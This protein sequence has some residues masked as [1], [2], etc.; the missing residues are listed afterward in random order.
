MGFYN[1]FCER[2]SIRCT[3]LWTI[4]PIL[5]TLGAPVEHMVTRELNYFWVSGTSPFI[6]KDDDLS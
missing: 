4:V 5:T 2:L 1:V 3:N 6:P